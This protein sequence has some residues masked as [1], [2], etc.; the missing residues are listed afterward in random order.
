MIF[1]FRRCIGVEI[2]HG[3]LIDPR[4]CAPC[5]VAARI[6][7]I[8]QAGGFLFINDGDGCGSAQWQTLPAA[9]LLEVR[10]GAA[11]IWAAA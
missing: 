3:W 10:N 9:D 1:T 8:V 4:T 6:A 5:R 7:Q 11:I 2:L